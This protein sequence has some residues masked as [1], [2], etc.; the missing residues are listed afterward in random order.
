[1]CESIPAALDKAGREMEHELERLTAE[2]YKLADGE[3]NIKL[4][5]SSEIS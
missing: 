4:R 5:L 1:M 2:I 3:F